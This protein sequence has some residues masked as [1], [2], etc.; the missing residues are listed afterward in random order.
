[1]KKIKLVTLLMLVLGMVKAQQTPSE[2]VDPKDPKAKSILDELSKK[3]KALIS[4]KVDF[5]YNLYNQ[6]EK[7]DETQ[8]GNVSIKG[9]K[10]I[11]DI[12]GQKIVCNGKTQWTYIKDADEVQID[13]APD[14]SK[15]A[16]ALN[17]AQIF[18]I[19]ETGFKYKYDKEDSYKT[20]PVHVIKLFPTDAN[21]KAY[22]TI[23]LAVYK[24]ENQF[25]Y[26]QI[27][28]KDGNRYTYYLDK[29]T[30]NPE[31]TDNDFNFDV[32]KAGEVI[33]LR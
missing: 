24:I 16:D 19:Y 21:A 5:S 20:K 17:P 18:T 22:H 8:K 32:T 15:K 31:L 1:M 23:I 33:D 13:N 28:S 14:P 29:F 2:A 10:F 25:A 11:L 26:I 7:I 30:A 27:L 9:S 4:M 12:A 6:T 3:N